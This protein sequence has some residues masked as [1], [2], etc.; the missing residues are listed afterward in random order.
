M[1]NES[2]SSGTPQASPHPEEELEDLVGAILA[3]PHPE[4][5]ELVQYGSPEDLEVQV[6]ERRRHDEAQ[7]QLLKQASQEALDLPPNRES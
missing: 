6:E 3:H 4:N 5:L 1:A 2:D 7:C